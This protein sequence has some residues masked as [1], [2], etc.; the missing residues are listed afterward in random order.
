MR[1]D[2]REDPDRARLRRHQPQVTTG[3][4]TRPHLARQVRTQAPCS[5]PIPAHPDDVEVHALSHSSPELDPG[6][7]V[8]ADFKHVLPRRHQARDQ[9]ELAVEPAASLADD[10][11]GRTSSAATS[12]VHTSVTSSTR[13]S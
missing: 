2:Q 13:T 1:L 5:P 10:S 8:S 7:L 4:H 9:T 3:P 6:E 11:V 12:A